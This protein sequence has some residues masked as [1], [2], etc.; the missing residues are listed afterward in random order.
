MASIDKEKKERVKFSIELGNHIRK[1]RLAKKLSLAEFASLC[2]MDK[3][4]YIRIEKGRVN[5][6][7][8]AINKIAQAL[9]LDL[10]EF[11]KGFSL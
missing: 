3:P 11:L 7:I 1:R 10:A 8:Y 4:N 2:D 9:E 6:S 5:A